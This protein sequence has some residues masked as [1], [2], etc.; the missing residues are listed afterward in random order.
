MKLKLSQAVRIGFIAI[1]GSM[2]FLTVGCRTNNNRTET[3]AGQ[4]C[5]PKVDGYFLQSI[6]QNVVSQDFYISQQF[7][8]GFPAGVKKH[9][10]GNDELSKYLERVKNVSL[11]PDEPAWKC[12]RN[13]ISSGGTRYLF[14]FV[15]NNG[16]ASGDMILRNGNIVYG[17]PEDIEFSETADHSTRCYRDEAALF[18]VAH[19]DEARHYRIIEPYPLDFSVFLR[20]LEL[21]ELRKMLKGVEQ[22]RHDKVGLDDFIRQMRTYYSD[23]SIF[24]TVPRLITE[25]L[26]QG[27]DLFFFKYS[28]RDYCDQGLVVIRDEKVICRFPKL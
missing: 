24:T 8:L 13:A 17:G 15:T 5:L 26:S 16:R 11:D 22:R 25:A 7:L 21:E 14:E 2:L 6:G 12:L 18:R 3:P 28:K 23:G 10:G 1:T 20:R 19:P 27:G 4:Q 9:A